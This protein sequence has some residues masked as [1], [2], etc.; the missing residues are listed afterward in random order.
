[1]LKQ[2]SRRGIRRFHTITAALRQSRLL[3]LFHD[4]SRLAHESP[5][6]FAKHHSLYHSTPEWKQ[7][8]NP[9]R[10]RAYKGRERLT[11][12]ELKANARERLEHKLTSV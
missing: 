4:S 5:H 3:R 6:Y 9:R 10:N 1:M 7:R 8:V 12:Q 11:R 2:Y